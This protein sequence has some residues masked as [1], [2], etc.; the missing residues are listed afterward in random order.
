MA[1][2]PARTDTE[3]SGN[4][5]PPAAPSP[6]EAPAAAS[7]PAEPA[8]PPAPTARGLAHGARRLRE[9]HAR[10]SGANKLALYGLVCA[11]LAYLTPLGQSLY[12]TLFPERAI[13]LI[14][15]PGN[16]PCLSSFVL[17]PGNEQ[18]KNVI[19]SSD[20]R[21]VGRWE[22]DGRIVHSGD[23]Q[24]AVTVRGNVDKAAVIRDISLTVVGRSRPV[25]GEFVRG[26]G[27]GAED[28]PEYLVVD[29]DT[30]PL[31]RAVPVSYLQHSPQQKAAKA[32][33]AELGK[34]IS[35]PK[36]VTTDGIYSFFLTGRS[37]KYDTRWVATV[38]WWDGEEDHV[39]RI[40]NS[41]KP[42]RVSG[43]AR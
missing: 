41:G 19:W 6:P 43:R 37:Q 21:Q 12:S 17:T 3:G 29:L 39:E 40:D 42:F 24:I 25:A 35:L 31:N 30:L 28:D 13:A 2:D 32:A 11:A 15:D 38:T 10:L 27:C 1:E 26:G 16:S 18:L 36:Q 20:R 7:A 23:A 34:P 4:T 33:A 14:V 8:A 22:S 5:R 9:R